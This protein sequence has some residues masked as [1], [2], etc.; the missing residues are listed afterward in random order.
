MS[1]YKSSATPIDTKSKLGV[2]SGIPYEDPTLFCS[3][4]G[5]LQ[6][7]TFTRPDISYAVQQLCLFMHAPMT[8]HMFALKS[9]LRYIQGTLDYGLH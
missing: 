1:S 9:V 5:A 2:V 6:I 7:L 4:A 8:D 3:L